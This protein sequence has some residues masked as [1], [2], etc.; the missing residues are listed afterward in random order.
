MAEEQR[1]MGSRHSL[2]RSAFQAGILSNGPKT[3]YE[4]FKRRSLEEKV[5]TKNR[6]EALQYLADLMRAKGIEV[7]TSDLSDDLIED[8]PP[9]TT[10]YQADPPPIVP[11]AALPEDDLDRQMQALLD[12]RDNEGGWFDDGPNEPQG[13][14]LMQFVR[15]FTDEWLAPNAHRGTASQFRFLWQPIRFEGQEF[16]VVSTW[17]LRQ[18][19]VE[20][21]LTGTTGNSPVLHKCGAD[22]LHFESESALCVNKTFETTW[23]VPKRFADS[24]FPGTRQKVEATLFVWLC[25]YVPNREFRFW[26]NEERLNPPRGM[27]PKKDIW[28][29][30]LTMK[31]AQ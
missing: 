28:K 21:N 18:P 20:W 13:S 17:R 24:M 22:V 1:I 30:R 6:I 19:G 15:R 5:P 26:L 12:E 4:L 25:K 23:D 27:L 8:L 29:K 2:V 9:V 3:F 7:D 16:Y 10:S 31:P 14:P 11:P